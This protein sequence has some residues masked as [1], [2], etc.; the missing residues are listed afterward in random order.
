MEQQN[1]V[2]SYTERFKEMEDHMVVM[3]QQYMEASQAFQITAQIVQDLSVQIRMLNDQIQAMYDLGVTT[4]EA[5]TD[6]VN[7]RRVKRVR[8][9]IANDEKAGLI[10]KLESA[11]SPNDIVVYTSEDVSLA[12]KAV[13]AFEA[14]GLSD[15]LIGKKAGDVIEGLTIDSVYQ[16]VQPEAKEQSNEQESK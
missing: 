4:R 7:E 3:S 11:Q 10:K 8:D 2:K 6:K 14:E 13:A 5:V 9:M 15:K 16:I 12:F 1:K